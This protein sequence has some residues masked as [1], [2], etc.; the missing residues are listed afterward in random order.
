MGTAPR[1]KKRTAFIISAKIFKNV[2]SRRP[3]VL[4][5]W[6]VI[7]GAMKTNCAPNTTNHHPDSHSPAGSPPHSGDAVPPQPQD[8]AADS[9]PGRGRPSTCTPSKL[10]AICTFIR[11]T[12]L[13][14]TAAAAM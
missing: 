1:V 13:S 6:H 3:P 10:Y 14:D 12:G 2:L 4:G 7:L 8:A 5:G 11:L 9:P